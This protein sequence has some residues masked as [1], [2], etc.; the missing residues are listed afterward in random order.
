MNET[1]I[2]ASWRTL[3][4]GPSQRRRIDARVAN[5][6]EAERTSLAAEWLRALRLEPVRVIGFCAVAAAWLML[7]SPVL[8]LVTALL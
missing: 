1:E 3:E 7:F 8:A 6:M 4:P 2:A 5:W